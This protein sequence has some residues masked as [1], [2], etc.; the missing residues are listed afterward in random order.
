MA[1][2]APG[3][4]APDFT[5][6]RDGG[7]TISL[8]ALRGRPVV[9]FFYPKDDTQACTL[10]AISFSEL[11]DEFAAAGIALIGL[12]PDSVKKHDRFAKKH[13]LTVPLAADEEKSVV[14]AYG[15]WVEKMMYGRKY[16][17][18]ERSTF[19]IGA[20]GVVVRVWE[21]VKVDGHAREVLDAA[22]AI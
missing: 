10:E 20:D 8:S 22:K 4:V 15:V 9:L 6:P 11:A 5:L 2:P 13:N 16:M 7:G 19:L 18:V 17:G 21:K 1:R 12:S 3:D 14:E